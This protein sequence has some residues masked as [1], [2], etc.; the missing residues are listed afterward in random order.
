[1]VFYLRVEHLLFAGGVTTLPKIV[2]L[3][4]VNRRTYCRQTLDD[5]V[6]GQEGNS[7][8]YVIRS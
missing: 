8:D 1:M 2:K 3:R 4:I 5:K 6:E 7:P